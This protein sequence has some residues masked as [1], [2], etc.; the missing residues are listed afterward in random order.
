MKRITF[1]CILV[2]LSEAAQLEAHAFLQHAEPGVGSTVQAAPAE[3][4]IWFSE[5]VE[6]AFSS[7]QVFNASGKVVDKRDLHL[8]RADH[9]LLRVSLL[10]L[11]PGIYKV[12]W[13]VVSADTHVTS[14]SFAFRIVRDKENANDAPNP[15]YPHLD[16]S[17]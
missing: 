15:H 4:R 12:V 3:V 10:K 6:P 8:D 7:I 17:S 1:V 16:R 11:P 5:N 9:A 13:R 14:G 2:L